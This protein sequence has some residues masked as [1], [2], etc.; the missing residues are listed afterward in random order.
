MKKESRILDILGQV[1][2]KYVGEAAPGKKANKKSSWMKWGAL[3]ACLCLVICAIT[4]PLLR[5]P[6]VTP[7]DLAPMVFVNDTIYY[8]SGNKSFSEMQDNFNYIGKIES[9]VAPSQKPNEELQANHSI[10]G[11]EVYQYGD[12]VVVLINGKY[13]LYE[14]KEK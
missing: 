14:Y 11:A 2:E 12:N 3:A 8:Q 9:E 5:E 1:D 6:A 4:I 10:V 13:W 7:G